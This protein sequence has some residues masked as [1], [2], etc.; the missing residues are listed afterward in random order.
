MKIYVVGGAIRDRLLGLPVKDLDYVV[1]GSSPEQMIREGF[2]PVGQDFPVF[3]HPITNAEYALA[4]TERKTAPGYKGFVFHA[5]ES[6]TLEEDLAR[7]DLTINAMA[8]LIDQ[9]NQLVGPIIDP[10]GGQEDLKNKIFRHVGPAF[11]ED[12]LRL[13][14]VARFAARFSD[15]TIAPETLELLQKISASGELRA[16]VRER[17]WQELAKGMGC[18][19]PSKMFLVLMSCGAD[20]EILPGVFSSNYSS[21]FLEYL[22]RSASKKMKLAQRFAALFHGLKCEVIKNLSIKLS[23]TIEC[24]DYAVLTNELAA[25]LSQPEGLRE[26]EKILALLDRVDVWRKPERF[27]ELLDVIELIPYET[28]VLRKAYVAAKV[29]D[30]AAISQGVGAKP[31]AGELIKAAIQQARIAAIKVI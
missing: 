21:K 28:I 23:A 18:D 8:Q 9:N 5:D 15:F 19:T 13:L 16:L 27:F 3:L 6:V 29:V 12:P 7:R 24:T 22:D 26:P 11:L 17:V 14:R 30:V 20:L 31:G 4:R 10:Y 2:K 1:V 25:C